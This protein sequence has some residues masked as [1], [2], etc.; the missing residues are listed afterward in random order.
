MEISIE[1]RE[2]IIKEAQELPSIK[3][4]QKNYNYHMNRFGRYLAQM[5]VDKEA[6]LTSSYNWGHWTYA[7]AIRVMIN[8]VHAKRVAAEG[9]GSSPSEKYHSL[10][11]KTKLSRKVL[12]IALNFVLKR[13]KDTTIKAAAE[14]IKKGH[15]NSDIIRDALALCEVLKEQLNLASEI[16]PQGIDIDEEYLATVTSEAQEALNL[17]GEADTAESERNILVDTQARLLTL[18][19]TAIDHIRDY[20]EATFFTDMEYLRKHYTYAHGDKHEID[21]GY[22]MT[23]DI[24]AIGTVE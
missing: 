16:T 11:E 13:T 9:K 3:R 20:A 23:I 21:D 22:D 6:L 17:Q 24:D 10:L 8:E 5:E 1:L 2:A 15:T 7:N 4:P 12:T 14:K 19:I 18:S